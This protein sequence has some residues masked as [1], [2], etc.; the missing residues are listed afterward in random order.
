MFTSAEE[1]GFEPMIFS[2]YTPFQKER[3]QPTQPFF[4]HTNTDV[5]FSNYTKLE[6]ELNHYF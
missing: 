1:I 5:I 6:M 2:Q 4:Q 3:L